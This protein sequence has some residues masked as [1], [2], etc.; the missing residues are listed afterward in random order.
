[1]RRRGIEA[2]RHQPRL[3]EQIGGIRNNEASR[4]RQRQGNKSVVDRGGRFPSHHADN[5][6]K[7]DYRQEHSQPSNACY[8]QHLETQ[9]A[10]PA[11]VGQPLD[12]TFSFV[13]T[14]KMRLTQCKLL[15]EG[16][17][18]TRSDSRDNSTLEPGDTM[19]INVRLI[20]KFS[21]ETNLIACFD[22]N[23]FTEIT[24]SIKVAVAK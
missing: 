20:P 14:L 13:N 16:P 18:L 3:L 7:G 10:S 11:K 12:V 2:T 8:I 23:E 21:G 5:R 6:H 22:S 24:G 15:F 17:G 4:G 19:R 9:V 1:M